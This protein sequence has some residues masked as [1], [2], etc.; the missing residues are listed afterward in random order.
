MSKERFIPPTSQTEVPSTVGRSHGVAYVCAN[1]REHF[2]L[3]KGEPVRC[4]DCGHR[5]LYKERT[6]RT[7]KYTFLFSQADYLRIL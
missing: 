5:V 3:A 4:K 7:S 2:T 6:R 1:C